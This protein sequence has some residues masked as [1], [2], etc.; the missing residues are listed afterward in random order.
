MGAFEYSMLQLRVEVQCPRFFYN[1]L[2]LPTNILKQ[3][4]PFAFFVVNA[5]PELCDNVVCDNV[6]R[7]FKSNDE[8]SNS[9]IGN[10]A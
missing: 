7:C 4:R 8:H 9:A 3:E 5:V 6:V 10:R 1:A 2:S